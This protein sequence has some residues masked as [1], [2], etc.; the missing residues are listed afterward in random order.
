M[1]EIR[2]SSAKEKVWSKM[3]HFTPKNRSFARVLE[4]VSNAQC[5]RSSLRDADIY[6]DREED[7]GTIYHQ[8]SLNSRTSKKKKMLTL[9][10]WSHKK[11]KELQCSLSMKKKSI[12]P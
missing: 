7:I 4:R 8:S 2:K 11:I 1:E 12:C 10:C 5:E 6:A 3:Q 9:E